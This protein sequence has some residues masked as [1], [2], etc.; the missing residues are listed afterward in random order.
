M[1]VTDVNIVGQEVP[2]AILRSGRPS[3]RCLLTPIHPS[4]RL[5]VLWPVESY[6]GLYMHDPEDV[7]VADPQVL[8]DMYS[9]TESEAR[10]AIDIA[11]GQDPRFIAE[12]DNRSAHTVRSQ[13]KSIFK[14][15]RC[16]RQ[17]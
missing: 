3:L 2:F 17:N 13:L 8:I 5:P 9:L 16:N 6:I 7:P 14:K 11:R 10:I 4:V 12:R 15:T 1:A